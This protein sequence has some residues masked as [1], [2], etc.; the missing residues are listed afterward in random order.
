M[1]NIFKKQD[2]K[3]KDDLLWIYKFKLDTIEEAVK[4]MDDEQLAK[5]I[6]KLF[7]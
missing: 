4:V 2:S 3:I 5:A 7:I 6:R 1:W